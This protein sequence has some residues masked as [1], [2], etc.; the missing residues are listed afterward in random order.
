MA[1]D[2]GG[3]FQEAAGLVRYFDSEEESA[4]H[5]DPRAV[6][7]FCFLVAITTIVFNWQCTPG[8]PCF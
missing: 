7:A 5:M 2:E 1:Q 3:G 6:I 8:T 4:I